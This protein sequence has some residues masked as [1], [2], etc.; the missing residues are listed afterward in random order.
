ML[1]AG[2]HP[3]RTIHATDIVLVEDDE[4]LAAVLHAADEVEAACARLIEA[5]VA[6]GAID[7][8]SLIMVDYGSRELQP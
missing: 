3:D 8:V 1:P 2:W 7:D 4:T 6:G 5:A